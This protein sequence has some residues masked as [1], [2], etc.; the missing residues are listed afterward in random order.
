[1]CMWY[2]H[3]YAHTFTH[4]YR[5]DAAKRGES[6]KVIN[7]DE[8]LVPGAETDQANKEEKTEI[9][10][11]TPLYGEWQTDLYIPLPVVICLCVCDICRFH[12]RM[13]V[14]TG[15]GAYHTIVWGMAD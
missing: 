15:N 8:D 10:H 2:V 7:L 14:K 6:S 12:V 4:T 5:A 3:T 11:T 1:M 13:C 9:E